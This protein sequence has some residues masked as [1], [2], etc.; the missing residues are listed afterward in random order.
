MKDSL[1]DRIKGYEDTFRHHLPMRMPVILRLDGK[2]FHSYTK[3]CKKPFDEKLISVMNQTAQKLCEVIQGV[4]LAY[5]QS[6]EIS[7]LINNYQNL[8][9]ESWF[10][11]NIQKMVSIASAIASV[12]FTNNSWQIWAPEKLSPESDP[13]STC[14]FNESAYFDCRAFV[15]PKD[16]VVNYFAWRQQ[17][18]TRNSVQMLARSLYS[19]KE[20]DNK[21]N[22]QL[23]EMCFQKGKNW[24]DCPTQFKRGRCLLKQQV[25]KKTWNPHEQKDVEVLR[26]VWTVD[27]EIP[28]F[29]Q[30]FNYIN[31]WV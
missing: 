7:L 15:L 31:K 1:G 16:E 29:T 19:H 30:D 23:Q 11:N 25:M 17:D 26:N 12:E 3:G 21:N 2:S 14:D 24:N 27:N 28:I 22:S 13:M 10:G 5:V 20:C 9:T 8:N 6:D 18:N 4:Q